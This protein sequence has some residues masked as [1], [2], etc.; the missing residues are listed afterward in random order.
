MHQAW[1]AD[2]KH[3]KSFRHNPDSKKKVMVKVDQ[4]KNKQ[5]CLDTCGPEALKAAILETWIA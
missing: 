3:L 2:T 5:N 1:G 4:N